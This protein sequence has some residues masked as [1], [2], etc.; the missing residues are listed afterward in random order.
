MTAMIETNELFNL[1]NDPK[2]KILDAT[3]PAA[4]ASLD[5]IPGAQFFD[6]DEISNPDSA[7]PHTAPT[8]ETFEMHMQAMGINQDD[9][10]VVYDQKN[11]AMAAA[12]AWWM[13]RLYGFDNVKVLNGGMRKWTGDGYDTLSPTELATRRFSRHIQT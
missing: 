9:T 10:V 7:L 12:R 1:L 5:I 11:V 3:Y 6:I 13:F 8:P 2:V 4:H